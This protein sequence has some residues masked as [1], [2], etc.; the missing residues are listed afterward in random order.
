VETQEEA[1]VKLFED[2]ILPFFKKFNSSDFRLNRLWTE[3]ND[4][5][6]KQNLQL[7]KD[8]Y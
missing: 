3:A 6:I 4:T 7:L 2:N 1:V 5:I 8:I